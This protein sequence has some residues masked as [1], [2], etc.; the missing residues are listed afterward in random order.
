[1][2]R[3]D[4]RWFIALCSLGCA[5]ASIGKS[6][7]PKPIDVKVVNA[8]V[9][10]GG[11]TCTL[12]T[13]G[14]FPYF[15]ETEEFRLE[16]PGFGFE[17]SVP[18]EVAS[19]PNPGVPYGLSFAGETTNSDVKKLS[20]LKSLCGLAL[21]GSEVSDSGLAD[22]A[23]I[24]S[25]ESLTLYRTKVTSG[26]MKYLAE[27]PVLK[28]LDVSGNSKVSDQG[29]MAIA[30]CK[31]IRSLEVSNINFTDIGIVHLGT[32]TELIALDMCNNSKV[33]NAGLGHLTGL[34]KLQL[35]NLDGVEFTDAGVVHLGRLSALR[36]LR[37]GGD[38]MTDAGL[39]PLSKPAANAVTVNS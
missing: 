32:M 25:V 21:G 14:P 16:F 33:T 30:E 15:V 19:L 1:M 36:V 35:L 20:G 29:L 10:A 18:N 4:R 12:G 37:F 3:G 23:R 38:N 2:L 6:G 13:A 27:M 9:R 11:R 34:R 8:W 24:K 7:E 22:I 5:F 26:G 39:Q 31:S 28:A 17:R